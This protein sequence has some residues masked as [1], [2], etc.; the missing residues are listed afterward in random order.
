M[1]KRYMVALCCLLLSLPV[2]ARDGWDPVK[3]AAAPG[4]VSTWVR[5]VEGEKA[6]EFMGQVD[7]PHHPLQ[8]LD[9]LDDATRLHEWA[10]RCKRAERFGNGVYMVIEGNWPASDRDVILQS[11]V[12]VLADRILIRS[13]AE[14]D[15]LPPKKD[16][17][18][19]TTMNN[20][21]EVIPLPDGGSRVIFQSFVDP[22]G[23]LP[24][25]M[26]NLVARQGA[27]ETLG[28][29]KKVLGDVQPNPQGER[30][31]QTYPPELQ[32]KVRALLARTAG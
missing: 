5:A 7:L 4:E 29:L 26:A 1:L 18:R 22:G 14:P 11:E 20:R 25:W 27:L 10:F 12:D 3:K 24:K 17:Y 28:D 9:A 2:L 13:H 19:I 30:L 6:K 16:L 15:L 23:N 21:F 31:S 32:N 8:V